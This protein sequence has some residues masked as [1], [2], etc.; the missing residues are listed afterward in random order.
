[1]VIDRVAFTLYFVMQLANRIATPLRTLTL[2]EQTPD[3]PRIIV[4]HSTGC[5][6]S[7]SSRPHAHA[8]FEL[9]FI[10]DGEGWYSTRLSKR[11]MPKP[12]IIMSHLRCDRAG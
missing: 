3:K 2:P 1:M 10:E 8:F 12:S 11:K 7:Q 9:F 4:F 5:S 6:N